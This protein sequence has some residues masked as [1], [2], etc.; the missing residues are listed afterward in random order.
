[1]AVVGVLG[2]AAPAS[3]Q[4][5]PLPSGPDPLPGSSF[6]GGDGDQEAVPTASP[7]LRDWESLQASGRLNHTPDETPAERSQFGGGTSETEP[8]G[9]YFVS[10]GA[11]GVSPDQTDIKDGWSAVTQPG[12]NT[13]LY[14]GFARGASTGT[15]QIN[16]E[17][18][19]DPELWV[20]PQGAEVPCRRNGDLLIGFLPKGN[21]PGVSVVLYRWRTET[22]ATGGRPCALTGTWTRFDDLSPGTAQGTMNPQPITNL[23]RNGFYDVNATMNARVFGE[24]ALNLTRLLTDV[25]DD[26][27]VS[28]GLISM[29]SHS[30]DT[31]TSAL[32]DW[33]KPRPL[34]VRT[35]SASG[36]KFWDRNADGDRD[37]G[38]GPLA[39]FRIWAD[40]FPFDGRWDRRVEPS[41][42]T[43]ERGEY[44][45]NDIIPPDGTY[46]LRERLL[47]SARLERLI[48]NRWRCSAP[49]TTG[50][51]GRFRCAHGPIDVNATPYAQ[52][53]DFGNWLPASITVEKEIFPPDDPGRFELLVD[54]TVVL[55]F[56]ADGASSRVFLRPGTYNVAERAAPP[57]DP[58][59]YEEPRVHCKTAVNRRGARQGG[60]VWENLELLSGQHATCTFTNIRIG[61]PAIGISKSARPLIVEAGNTITYTLD[62]T[63]PGRVSFAAADVRVTDSR[64]DD[65]PELVEKRQVDESGALADD[66]SP[67][68]LDFED[69]WTY[70]CTHRTPAA[71]AD[72]QAHLVR[73]LA[74]VRGTANGQNVTSSDE[75][76][77]TVLCPDEPVPPG[78]E[79]PGPEPPPGPTPPG[80]GP[81]PPAATPPNA[82]AAGQ[83]GILFRRAIRG[84]IETRVPRVDFTGSRVARIAVYVN[85]RVRRRLTMQSLQ[86]R[87]TPRVT[88]AP[89]KRY[90]IAVRV[91]FQRGSGTPPVTLRGTFRT[92]PARAPAVTG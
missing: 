59:Q 26:A 87:V 15:S 54:D 38:E 32:K 68:T 44:V 92:C 30:S 69:V 84:C 64:C 65:A 76:S 80:P 39:N 28:F 72:C 88:V 85:G 70:R 8:G 11:G 10:E 90:R 73:N 83:A 9:W 27:C 14:L 2:L 60:A 48:S 53:R 91:T 58:T 51:G 34:T 57:T 5:P 61:A 23:L 1:V 41:A 82:G 19:H 20:N 89:G 56:P 3:A 7:P 25:L 6:Q 16:V 43:D 78:P 42:I 35:C 17:L 67:Q 29:H 13:F 36:T 45:I 37:P 77:V 50:P 75:A 12:G 31:I 4:L 66:D 81:T 24:T 62:V 22:A 21:D 46:M 79:P 71:G 63:N 47:R 52:G 55:H 74:E 49:S 33:V 86:R 40:Y 18:N